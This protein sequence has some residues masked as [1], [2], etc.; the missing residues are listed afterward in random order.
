MAYTGISR[1]AISTL[2]FP[3]TKEKALNNATAKVV[4]FKPPPVDI[5]EAPMSI[6]PTVRNKVLLL[7]AVVSKALNPAVRGVTAPKKE[8]H[9]FPV[10]ERLAKL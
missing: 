1:F 2:F 4:V 9:S 10:N 6:K 8:L 3:L 7:K 5:G